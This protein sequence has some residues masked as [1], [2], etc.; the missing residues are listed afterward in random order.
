MMAIHIIS[1]MPEEEEVSEESGEAEGVV[2][3][4]GEDGV[5]E[6]EE[7]AEGEDTTEALEAVDGGETVEAVEPSEGEGSADTENTA[8]ETADDEAEEVSENQ[9]AEEP[10][11]VTETPAAGPVEIIIRDLGEDEALSGEAAGFVVIDRERFELD[12]ETLSGLVFEIE[13]EAVAKLTAQSVEE[14]LAGGI[15]IQLLGEGET[16][17]VIR[18][19]GEAEPLREIR[20]V[21]N[22]A[23][24]VEEPAEEEVSE[25][26]VVSDDGNDS[27]EDQNL[28]EFDEEISPD[29]IIS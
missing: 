25:T 17:L 22:A 20:L 26:E 10:A 15:E 19:E 12:D 27:V 23:P 5:I 16:R 11:E 29:E 21:V 13:N 4:G 28:L 3:E 8:E 6:S 7:P 2:T 9:E 14:L 24:A 18:Q 1:A